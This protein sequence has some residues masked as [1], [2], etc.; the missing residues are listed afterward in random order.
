M[1]GPTVGFVGF[2]FE[3]GDGFHRIT[4]WQDFG[5]RGVKLVGCGG[6]SGEGAVA[7][8]VEAT[9][10]GSDGVGQE[11]VVIGDGEGQ[12]GLNGG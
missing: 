12:S 3:F 4:R 9:G 5:V 8:F 7:F 6:G 10:D 1:L 2:E 11:I